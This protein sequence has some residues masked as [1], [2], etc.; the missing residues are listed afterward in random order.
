MASVQARETIKIKLEEEKKPQ[1][2]LQHVKLL[3]GP[4]SASPSP[5]RLPARE[6]QELTAG[7]R[8]RAWDGNLRQEINGLLWES[9]PSA[10][11]SL[12][13]A[14]LSPFP[15]MPAKEDSGRWDSGC[16]R[17]GGGY[18]SLNTSRKHVHLSNFGFLF[19]FLNSACCYKK[20][21]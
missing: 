11:G 7:D 8:A 3:P 14:V 4:T 9:S 6:P 21:V 10:G 5:D 16:K 18:I 12:A 17:E 20:G 2:G 19:L 1:H 13:A 15:R